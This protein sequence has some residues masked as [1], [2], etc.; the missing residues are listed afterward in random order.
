MSLH[1]GHHLGLKLI[2]EALETTEDVTETYKKQP[3]SEGSDEGKRSISEQFDSIPQRD[4]MTDE[5]LEKSSAEAAFDSRGGRSGV[6][7]NRPED[8]RKWRRGAKDQSKNVQTSEKTWREH[9]SY[10]PQSDDGFVVDD[11]AE[12]GPAP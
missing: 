8:D 7:E 6:Q 2:K 10:E 9:D 12:P 1:L 3:L 4:N 11:I 5:S